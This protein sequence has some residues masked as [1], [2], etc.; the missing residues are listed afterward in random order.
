MTRCEELMADLG[1]R[2]HPDVV[3]YST[4]VKGYCMAGDLD[5]A[6]AVLRKMLDSGRHAPDEILF[7]SLLDGCARQQRVEEA[8]SLVEDMHSHHV[9]PSNYTLSILVKLLGRSR[10][11]QQAFTMVEETCKR[12]DFQAN[13]H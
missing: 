11:L 3:T 9:R 2:G 4:L 7:N 5:R 1:A 6:F 8:L 13:I 10:R 12:F